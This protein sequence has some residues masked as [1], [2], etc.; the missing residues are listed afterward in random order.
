MLAASGATE[1]HRLERPERVST[2]TASGAPSRVPIYKFAQINMAP[3]SALCN[4]CLRASIK[5]FTA[6][7]PRALPS[8][9]PRRNVL[10]NLAPAASP[11]EHVSPAPA[12]TFSGL[13]VPSI[14]FA[15]LNVLLPPLAWAE[16]GATNLS[17]SPEATAAA[18][19]VVG[20]NGYIQ[21]IVVTVLFAS[22]VILLTVVTL[23]VA[24]L[25]FST[26]QDNTKEKTDAESKGA[27]LKI[28]DSAGNATAAKK[29]MDEGNPFKAK[30]KRDKTKGFGSASQAEA[31]KEAQNLAKKTK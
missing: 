5:P 1:Q 20:D 30:V 24:Y 26:W 15:T 27:E 9:L 31:E 11:T 3:V 23:G 4:P 21:S 10:A 16:Q 28:V 29:L 6:S 12:N 8:I 7:S 14:A 17:E 2:G 19:A 25:T 13:A 18:A 22:V